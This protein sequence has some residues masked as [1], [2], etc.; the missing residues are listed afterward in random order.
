MPVRRSAIAI[1]CFLLSLLLVGQIRAA[2]E[3]AKSATL[4]FHSD[5]ADP[6]FGAV[7]IQ[8]SSGDVMAELQKLATADALQTLFRVVVDDARGP[9]CLTS[10]RTWKMLLATRHG[11]PS[12]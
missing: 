12:M 6:A 10:I 11:D 2:P 7:D 5:P 8:P 4:S 9:T 3:A 1:A